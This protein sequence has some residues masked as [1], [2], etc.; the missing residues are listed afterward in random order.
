[1]KRTIL[2]VLMVVMV[3]TPCLAQEIET[4]GLFSIE[5][6]LWD[7]CDI[8]IQLSLSI[9]Q[10]FNV[11]CYRMGFYQGT[12]YSCLEHS[13]CRPSSAPTYIDSPVLSIAFSG[14]PF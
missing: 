9:D 12:V 1:M 13:G 3:S 4:D 7:V 8:T 6:T 2:A 11:E 10:P 14:F 5:G